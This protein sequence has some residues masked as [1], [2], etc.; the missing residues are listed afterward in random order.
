MSRSQQAHRMNDSDNFD[1]E[2]MKLSNLFL[3][4]SDWGGKKNYSFA[5]TLKNN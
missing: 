3:Y 4:T 1:E 2:D 5:M